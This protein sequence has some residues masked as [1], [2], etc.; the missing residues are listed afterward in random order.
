MGEVRA[1]ITLKLTGELESAEDISKRIADYTAKNFGDRVKWE[2]F[3]DEDTGRVVWLNWLADVD[4]LLEWEKAMRYSGLRA[5]AI[6][7]IFEILR[8]EILTQVTDP[9]LMGY[10][11]NWIQLRSLLR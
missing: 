6:P 9:R 4:T 7:D 5:E 1:L 2:P 8:V 11:E 10:M 3:I